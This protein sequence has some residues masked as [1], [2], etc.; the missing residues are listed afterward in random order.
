MRYWLSTAL[1]AG[2]LFAGTAQT[3]KAQAQTAPAQA[4]TALNIMQATAAY[5]AGKCDEA[6]PIL[7]QLWN[8]KALKASD[9][10]LAADFRSKRV[11]CTAQVSGVAAALPLSA[12]N[13]KEAPVSVDAYGLHAFLQ[14]SNNQPVEASQTLDSALDALGPKGVDLADISVLGTLVLL[15]DKDKARQTALM[16]HLEDAHWQV[17]DITNRP[18]L[19]LFRLE[20]LRAGRLVMS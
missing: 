16:A 13:L 17:H 1:A 9:P 6:L 2:L 19:D 12:E 15:Q 20:A 11:L 4:N 18:V 8:D 3:Q 10:A 5:D 7:E 14:L